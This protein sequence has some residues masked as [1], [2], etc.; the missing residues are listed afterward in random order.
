M[1]V[2]EYVLTALS[3]GGGFLIAWGVLKNRVDQLERQCKEYSE[4]IVRVKAEIP[5]LHEAIG[6]TREDFLRELND[7]VTVS[8]F[9][10]AMHKFEL[11]E[12]DIKRLI[13]MVARIKS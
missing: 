9:E 3:A 4:Q 6:T 7:Y 13:E 1:E 2:S 8:R 12:A 11:I 5:K 10:V